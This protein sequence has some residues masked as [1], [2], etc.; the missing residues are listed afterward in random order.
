MQ[1]SNSKSL[2][3]AQTT[4]TSRNQADIDTCMRTAGRRPAWNRVSAPRAMTEEG[5]FPMLRSDSGKSTSLG[6]APYS[7][8]EPADMSLVSGAGYLI[9]GRRSVYRSFMK[10]SLGI[11][12]KL[13][14]TKWQILD[15]E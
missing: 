14:T 10:L 9:D 3:T 6:R 5:T 1:S 13:G 4:L 7:R 8:F 2:L 15:H 12:V 11:L